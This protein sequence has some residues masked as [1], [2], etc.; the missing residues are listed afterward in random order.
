MNYKDKIAVVT[1]ASSGIGRALAY[2]FAHRGCRVVLAA[3][4]R[5][6]CKAW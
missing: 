1:G 2:E 6:N 3:A 4:R 5:T